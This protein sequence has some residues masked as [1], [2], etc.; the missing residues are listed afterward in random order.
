M[1]D[2]LAVRFLERVGDLNSIAQHLFGGQRS[3]LEAFRQRLALEVLENQIVSLILAA[4]IVESAD[5]RMIE[6][7]N[8]PGLALKAPSEVR[9]GGKF[10]GQDLDGDGTIQACVASAIHL[11]HTARTDQ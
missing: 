4:D 10:G 7:G 5:V 2:A 1:N 9:V 3:A 11:A 8:S 6:A